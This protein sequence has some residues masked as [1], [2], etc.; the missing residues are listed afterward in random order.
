MAEFT[1][2]FRVQG[3]D[4]RANPRFQ[5]VPAGGRRYV[6][7]RDGEG[8]LVTSSNDGVCRVKEVSVTQ[9][10]A[11][12]RAPFQAGD[13]F[14]Q[15]DGGTANVAFITAVDPGLMMFPVQL[16][17]GVKNELR[18]LVAFNFVRDNAG[19][20]TTRP[21]AE[22]AGLMATARFVWRRQ[23]NVRL[24][25]YNIRRVQVP[26]NLGPTVLLPAGPLILGATGTAI[27]ATGVAGVHLNVFFVRD[28]QQ[29]ANAI[30]IDAVTTLGPHTT[31]NPGVCIFEDT[32][33]RDQ[34]LTLAHEIGHHL[35]LDHP[36]HVNR[37]DLMWRA[38][39][40][41]GLNLTRAD[42][43]TANP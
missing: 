32:A 6:I 37:V 15:L 19:H 20:H 25:T 43:N 30:D 4:S 42:I 12:D 11:D 9:L 26:M 39:D 27:A 41:R 8:W 40:D 22:V 31:A 18:Q 21:T 14:F 3:L 29:T 2:A 1:R 7:L 36:G 10:P 23:A 5:M 24:V 38:T 33:G 35:G 34:G 13:R 17:V 28:L 16:E